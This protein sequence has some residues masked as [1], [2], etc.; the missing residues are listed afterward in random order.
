MK[1][2]KFNYD[3]IVIKR[4]VT[5]KETEKGKVHFLSIILF[6]KVGNPYIE[7]LFITKSIYKGKS[8]L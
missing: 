6:I 5:T 2:L 4:K 7:M 3:S 1:H 8:V